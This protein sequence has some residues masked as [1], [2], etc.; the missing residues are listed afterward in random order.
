MQLWL[1]P[2]PFPWGLPVMRIT[3][4]FVIEKQGNWNYLRHGPLVWHYLERNP[5]AIAYCLAPLNRLSFIFDIGLM[6][7]AGSK[8]QTAPR[9]SSYRTR[10]SASLKMKEAACIRSESCESLP[11]ITFIG[12]AVEDRALANIVLLLQGRHHHLYIM[13]S[14]ER[15]DRLLLWAGHLGC[16]IY[17]PYL[18][19]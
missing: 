4:W 19:L 18:L 11:S 2:L 14:R 7:S 15:L 3:T 1:H 9:S 13:C 16:Y 6:Q 12:H 8:S 17:Q 5:G 10:R